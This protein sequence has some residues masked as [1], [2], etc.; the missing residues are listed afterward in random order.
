[1]LPLQ[2]KPPL[3]QLPIRLLIWPISPCSKLPRSVQL[4]ASCS[5]AKK[6]TPR[7]V[8]SFGCCWCRSRTVKNGIEGPGRA[9]IRS[10]L[11]CQHSGKDESRQGFGAVENRS[12]KRP[13]HCS[14]EMQPRITP[15]YRK[16]E[17]KQGSLNV[18]R[19]SNVT[20]PG[21]LKKG[22]SKKK[23]RKAMSVPKQ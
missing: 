7:G 8:A 10:G 21:R 3:S 4:R 5:R 19:L 14:P 2:K 13:R 20:D 22:S 1:M 16:G 15:S 23:L 9:R 17:K 11:Q 18:N 6:G 12:R